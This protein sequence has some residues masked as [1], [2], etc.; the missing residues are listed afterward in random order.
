MFDS[1]CVPHLS[2]KRE[3]EAGLVHDGVQQQQQQQPPLPVTNLACHFWLSA[4]L[5]AFHMC[6]C[7]SF[8]ASGI[9]VC[10]DEGL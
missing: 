4:R 2:N 5:L 10:K 7:G 3:I 1:V 9:I 8:A 6:S